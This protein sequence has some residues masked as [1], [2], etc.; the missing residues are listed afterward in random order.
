MKLKW[1]AQACA[2]ITF[3][4]LAFGSCRDLQGHTPELKPQDEKIIL[5]FGVVDN[6]GGTLTTKLVSEIITTSKELKKGDEVIFT[7]L[8]QDSKWAVENWTKK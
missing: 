1:F 5:T 2:F 4:L 6:A 8:P 3:S 7:A